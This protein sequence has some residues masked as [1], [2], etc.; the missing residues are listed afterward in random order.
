MKQRLPT[1]LTI[2]STIYK[3]HEAHFLDSMAGPEKKIHVP[4]D[5]VAIAKTLGVNHHILFGRLYFD[6]ERRFG[7]VT[8]S[9]GDTTSRVCLFAPLAGE[10]TN[11]VNFPLLAGV[12][13]GMQDQD[14]KQRLA[15]RLSIV[16]LSISAVVAVVTFYLRLK[17]IP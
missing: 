12:V 5:I 14:R 10:T 16:A 8:S 3:R 13:A 4:I 17:G 9:K 6:L 7:Y 11:C 15:V 1:D 2:L